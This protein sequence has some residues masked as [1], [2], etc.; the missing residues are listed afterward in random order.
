[1]S[2][3]ASGSRKKNVGAIVGGTL[4][5]I[6][7]IALMAAALLVWRQRNIEQSSTPEMYTVGQSEAKGS[8]DEMR[9]NG[10]NANT[11]PT[12]LTYTV[13]G[14]QSYLQSLVAAQA[15][16]TEPGD[17]DQQT[18]LSSKQAAVRQQRQKE[19]E[20]QIRYLQD[21]L[22]TLRPGPGPSSTALLSAERAEDARQ[23]EAMREHIALLQAQQ[24]SSW[25]QGLTDEPPPGYT[26]DAVVT[27]MVT[28]DR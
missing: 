11:V 22:R 6:T 25:A 26:A 17:S 9:S 16:M 5:G 8:I 2:G 24:H 12:P 21:E 15:V 18:P 1:M 20:L 13:D 10:Q 4:G 28:P 19:L 23:M 7:A 27:R 3:M 14:Q